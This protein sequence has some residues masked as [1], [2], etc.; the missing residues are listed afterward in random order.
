MDLDGNKIESH[1]E[2]NPGT[3]AST[4]DLTGF[5]GLTVRHMQ[6]FVNA[7][8]EG[9]KLKAPINDASISTHLCHLG[10]IAQELEVS[11]KV[12]PATGKILDNKMAMSKWGRSYEKGW[13]VKV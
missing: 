5:D 4:K 7:I 3:S 8:R 12:D 2:S 1:S 13:E 9:E 6:N 10:N 11:L